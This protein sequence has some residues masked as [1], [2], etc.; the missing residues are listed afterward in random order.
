[1]DLSKNDLTGT[2][3]VRARSSR[4]EIFNTIKGTFI[5]ENDTF[6][7]REFPTIKNALYKAE[8][9]GEEILSTQQYHCV[10]SPAQAQR[11]AKISLERV[12]QQV[13][14]S[15]QF[16]PHVIGLAPG[17]VITFTDADL[18]WD[19]KYFEVVGFKLTITP[20]NDASALSVDLDLKE[21]APWVYDWNAN[22]TEVDYSPDTNLPNPFNAIAPT[23]LAVSG[24]SF[25]QSDGSLA[26]GAL[27]TWTAP[28]DQYVLS[29]GAILIEYKTAASANWIPF[30]EVSGAS[31][32]ALITSIKANQAYDYRIRSRN[33]TGVMSAWLAATATVWGDTAAPATVTGLTATAGTG[34]VVQVKWTANTEAD[35]WEYYVYRNTVNNSGTASLVAQVGSNVFV[36][37]SVAIGGTYYYW[38]RASDASDNLGGISGVAAVTVTGVGSG[39]I[40]QTAPSAPGAIT[41]STQGSYITNDG[42]S[43]SF[44][45]VNVPAL[46]SGAVGQNVLIRSDSSAE[47]Q[48]VSQLTNTSSVRVRI[49]DLSPNKMYFLGLIAFSFAG[50]V[51]S[52]TSSSP[53]S[54]TTAADTTAPAVPSGL[55]ASSP[56]PQDGVPA[57][58]LGSSLRFAAL[59]SWAAVSDK[60]LAGYEWQH[61]Y[62]G[63]SIISQGKVAPSALK[64]YTYTDVYFVGSFKVRSFDRSGNYSAWA[65]VSAGGWTRAYA[66]NLG[67]QNY[68]DTQLSG[69]KTGASGASSTQKVLARYPFVQGFGPGPTGAYSW[70]VNVNLSNRGFS[71]RPDVVTSYV[72]NFSGLAARYYAPESGN[73]SSNAVV[74]LTA[75]NGSL[76]PDGIYIDLIGEA[77]EYD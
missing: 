1:M 69:I 46:P 66:G 76:L 13:A 4:R 70:S 42:S 61:E 36:D 20:E 67:V 48:I 18:G 14:F 55:V 45:D 8:D 50:V 19:Y 71:T 21:T 17:D 58:Y 64:I 47:W 59:F 37:T 77:I 56:T 10:T 40:D 44:A 7:E 74:T 16:G 33:Y 24:D 51:S 22:E 11:L 57:A 72:G 43:L 60:D 6:L 73:T 68:D 52:I 2:L 65:S 28:L 38:V 31:T 26:V 62:T 75:T 29:G 53:S 39:S 27:L 63:G 34:R 54:F 35:L 25:M 32:R 5:S 41:I 15:G 49:D 9:G 12:R 23:S 30:G 3:S